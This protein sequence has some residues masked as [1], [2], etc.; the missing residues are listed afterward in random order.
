[1]VSPPIYKSR[2][3]WAGLDWKEAQL[4]VANLL[5]NNSFMVF[6]EKRLESHKR[7]DILAIQNTDQSITFGILEVKC[8]KKITPQIQHNAM[9]QACR[10]LKNIF[11]SLE[12]NNR[13]GNKER[14]YFVATVFTN[15]YPGIYGTHHLSEYYTYLPKK[16]ISQNNIKLISSTPDSLIAKLQNNGMSVGTQ[17]SVD[18]FFSS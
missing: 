17:T 7:V 13:W 14:K 11:P 3:Y 5:N 12:N 18:E 6:E 2:A 1:M 15:D 16:L 8:Y 4:E 10:Y 9:I